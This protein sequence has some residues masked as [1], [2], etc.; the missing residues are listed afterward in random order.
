[1]T[2]ADVVRI[3]SIHKSK[4]LEFPITFVAGLSKR[5]NMQDANQAL[6]LDMDF[7][8]ATD[9]VNPGKRLCNK[10]LRSSV[11]QRKMREDNLA[12]EL[13]VL[14]VALTRAKEKLIL[15]ACVDKAEEKWE[16]CKLQQLQKLS[17]IDFMESGSYLDF[18]LP[19][20]PSACVEVKVVE[21]EDLLGTQ[22]R[23][24]VEMYVGKERLQQAG[25]FADREAL[26]LL[27]ERFSY[28]YPYIN[29]AKLYTKTTVSELKIA[30]MAQKDEAAHHAF[31]EK[32]VVPYYPKFLR[33]EEKV[34]A[35][36]RGNAY[37]RVMELLDFEQVL[38]SLFEQF[39]ETYEDYS[40]VLDRKALKEKLQ[41]FLR[42]EME[43]LRLSEEYYHAIKV[44]KIVRFLEN[45][46]AHRMWSAD[47]RGDL[48][49]EQ[50][51]VYGVGANRLSSD[52]PEE[53]NVL[54]Q[55][56]IDVFLWKKA[57]WYYWI[58]RQM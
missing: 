37:H 17:Y 34:S 9:Y 36:V 24:Q 55:G 27:Q 58:I 15:T 56:I 53:E 19:I 40:K 49:R 32:E 42:K 45:P 57:K 3:M 8:L 18:L 21:T 52:F 16:L 20:L 10:T 39:P 12:E 4:G 30:A 33:T 22:L 47:R 6:V 48:Y 2:N 29:L 25:Q 35:T 44:E 43:D 7:G 51:F 5:F 46:I 11:L 31:E 14:Y 50:P 26:A 38:G 23:E 54:I 13:R 28:R 1:M 41:E